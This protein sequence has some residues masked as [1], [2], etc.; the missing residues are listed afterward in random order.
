V[1][2]LGALEDL[3]LVAALAQTVLGRIA[4]AGGGKDAF[5]VGHV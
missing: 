5:L 1:R 2:R 3:E 4:D